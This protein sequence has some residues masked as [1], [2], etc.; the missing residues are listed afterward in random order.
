[1]PTGFDLS[2]LHLGICE[3]HE[4]VLEAVRDRLQET[5][6]GDWLLAVHYDQNKF[7]GLAHLHRDQLD[8]VSSRVPIL[9]RHTNGHASVV[10]SAA[11]LAAGID[12]STPD[13]KGGSY[14]RDPSGRLT[15]VL[16]ER[17]HEHVTDFAPVPTLEQR[18][19]AVML[20]SDAMSMHGITCASDMMTGYSDLL[21]EMEAYRLASERGAKTRFRLYLQWSPL[22]GLRAV[23][24]GER[25]SIT[26]TM[27]PERCRVAG[28]KIFA[29][30]A[31]SA[32]TAA[33]YAE[34]ASGGSGSLIYDPVRLKEMVRIA[35]DAGWPIAVHSIG[36]R[37]TD[38]V[39]EAFEATGDPSRH[40][41][42]HAMVASDE[43]IARIKKADVRVTMQPEFLMRLGHAYRRQLP[44]DV[45][46]RLKRARSFLDAG[47][48]LSFNS[49][50]PIVPGDPWDGILTAST[51]PDGFDQSEN[52]SL[53]EAI[54]LYTRAGAEANDDQGSMGEIEEG[55]LAD[56]Q[57]YETEI[58]TRHKPAPDEVFL[59]GEPVYR[60]G[61]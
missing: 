43:Q 45:F 36:D 1:M 60:K 2:R 32:G 33:I 55:Q 16:L 57:V 21:E 12:E 18:I 49:D 26:D 8:A 35:H 31:I 28:A 5:P 13:P 19:Q 41:L 6:D 47:V 15:G 24:E 54:D 52:V 17:A 61:S 38:L 50:R 11:L 39:L 42:E 29:D 14:V 27:D 56:F 48:R 3:T 46:P 37:S 25:L 53:A 23:S 4:Q 58:G 34:Y 51:R 40:R 7:P 59:G 10:N 22:F 44:P 30:G 20:A 9:L